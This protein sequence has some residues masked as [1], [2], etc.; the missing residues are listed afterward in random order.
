[1][2]DLNCH[3]G[4]V[5]QRL[6]WCVALGNFGGHSRLLGSEGMFWLIVLRTR[7]IEVSLKKLS[8]ERGACIDAFR[9]MLEIK[10]VSGIEKICNVN[11]LER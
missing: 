10:I 8:W 7:F 5:K 3:K 2:L 1:M 11:P 4:K 6:Q 9:G